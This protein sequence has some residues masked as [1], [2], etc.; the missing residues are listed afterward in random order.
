MEIRRADEGDVVVLELRGRLLGGDDATPL[1]DAVA[2]LVSGKASKVLLDLTHVPWMNSSGVGILVSAYAS[3]RNADAHVK[4][5]NLNERIRSILH[6]TRLLA[7]LESYDRREDALA[8][9]RALPPG[10]A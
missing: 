2:E 9:F 8:S 6:I 1:R 3:L 10:R 5:L 7:V 4:F